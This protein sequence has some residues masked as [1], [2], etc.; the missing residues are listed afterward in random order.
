MVR[1][2]SSAYNKVLWASSA[3]ELDMIRVLVLLLVIG[4]V[5]CGPYDKAG[6]VSDQVQQESR[7]PRQTPQVQLAE[8]QDDLLTNSIGMMLKPV[9][10]GAYTMGE[11]EE[12]HQVMLRR[13]FLLGVYE[14]TQEQYQRVMGS[15]PSKFVGPQYPVENVSWNDA[16]EFCRKL[17][18]LPEEKA[19]GRVYRLPTEAEWE[20]ACRAGTTTTYSFG[21]DE[22]LLSEY[23]WSRIDADDQTH[24]VGQKKPNPWGFYDM[25]GNVWEWC[26]DLF[27][28]SSGSAR[29][30]RGGSW[31][32]FA[33]DCRSASRSKNYPSFRYHYNGFRVV[34]VLS[35]H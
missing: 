12:S 1:V 5:G 34:C 4:I 29:V 11:G 31:N 33:T 6:D 8:V 32:D 14:V 16:M 19:A 17:S 26:G 10:A 20:Y 35:S 13:P 22:S 27:N 24:A 7:T 15:N 2:D 28:P 21:D 30:D 25:H 18:S 9:P 3:K 23:A